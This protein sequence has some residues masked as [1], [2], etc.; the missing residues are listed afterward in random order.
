MMEHYILGVD[1]KTPVAATPDE[2][3]RWFNVAKRHV[4][5]TYVGDGYVST[6]FLGL[7]YGYDLEGKPILW[8]SMFFGSEEKQQRYTSY[9]DAIA[10]HEAMVAEVKQELRH[11]TSAKEAGVPAFDPEPEA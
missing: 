7:N 10:G 8:E 9:D 11:D 2:W 6:V 4:A 1:G 5:M 3:S